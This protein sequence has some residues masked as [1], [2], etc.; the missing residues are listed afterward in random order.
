[1]LL[2]IFY[3]LNSK[4]LLG[5]GYLDA[6]WFVNEKFYVL[7]KNSWFTSGLASTAKTSANLNDGCGGGA[8]LDSVTHRQTIWRAHY[9]V[10]VKVNLLR[11]RT[12]PFVFEVFSI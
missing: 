5:S 9:T 6:T 3:D 12:S 11:T 4:V 1:M 8:L 10:N 7:D 2:I